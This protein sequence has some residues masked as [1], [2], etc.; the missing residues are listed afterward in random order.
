MDGT[1]PFRQNRVHDHAYHV[2][3]FFPTDRL[4]ISAPT[5]CKNPISEFLSPFV[6]IL[7]LEL[8]A[9][10]NANHQIAYMK[11]FCLPWVPLG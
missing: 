2:D 8:F 9:L 3:H 4:H 5:S 1:I 6:K 11:C 10:S 7:Y